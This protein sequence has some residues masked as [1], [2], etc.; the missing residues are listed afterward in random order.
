ME[1]RRNP[2]LYNEQVIETRPLRPLPVTPVKQKHSILSRALYPVVMV[3]AYGLMYFFNQTSPTM[4]LFPLIMLIPALV[5][6]AIEDRQNWKE[7][8]AVYQAEIVAYNSYLDELDKEFEQV[9]QSFQLWDAL[10]FPGVSEEL[11]RCKCLDSTLWCKRAECNDFMTLCLGTYSAKFPIQLDI[12]YGQ[13]A[14]H[15]D[16]ELK[17]RIQSLLDK[18][19][20][21]DNSPL[22]VNL[23]HH[24]CLGICDNSGFGVTQEYLA[25][26][27][28]SAIYSYGYDEV[29]IMVIAKKDSEISL[30]EGK[31]QWTRW[32]PHCWDEDKK[33]RFFAS[34]DSEKS[35]LLAY[36]SNICQ[37]RVS[38]EKKNLPYY[39][40]LVEDVEFF[41]KNEIRKFFT[42][43]KNNVG[44]GLIF[45]SDSKGLPS[46]S[47][48]VLTIDKT[49]ST[50]TNASMFGL[51]EIPISPRKIEIY[52]V[53]ELS[54]FLSSIQLTDD[55]HTNELP[56]LTTLYD[57]HGEKNLSSNRLALN[58]AKNYCY[59][60]G[61]HAV[62]G[63]RTP[64]E[65]MDLDMSDEHDGAHML[66]AGTTGSGK[67]E[68]LQTF[69]LALA[70]RY[71]PDEV[72]FVFID[73]KEGGMSESFRDLPHNAG[74]LTNIDDEIDYFAGRA[75]TMLNN[76]RKRRAKLLEPFG[77]KINKYHEAYHESDSDLVPLPHL[78]IVIDEFA[79]VISQC[80][81]F[82][83]MIISLSRVGRSL[84][85]HLVLATQSP[86]QSVDSQIWSNSNC[87]IC[88]KV[89]NEDESNAVLKVKDAAYIQTRGRAYSLT[90]G[91]AGL[92]A[93]QTAW[94]GAP[95]SA[96][97][98]AT[99]IEV[100]K[101]VNERM[102]LSKE[103]DSTY[104][105]STQLT[106][107]CDTC[108]AVK[109][110]TGVHEPHNVLTET[111]PS[112]LKL[113][114]DSSNN[115][116]PAHTPCAYIGIGDFI[117][118][119]RQEPVSVAFGN[120]NNH[121]LIAGT[122]NS[123]RSNV[124]GQLVSQL[125]TN[126]D[127][128]DI[129]FY[130]IQYGSKSLQT[131]KTSP[132]VSEYITNLVSDISEAEEKIGRT[133]AFA[134]DVIKY[135]QSENLPENQPK[136]VIVVD[137]WNQLIATFENYPEELLSTMSLNPAQYG[138]HF[139][140]IS[141]TEL[142]GYRL[143][144]YFDTKVFMK[145]DK[146]I[147]SVEDFSF[148]GLILPKQGRALYFDTVL[149][150]AVEIQTFDEVQ[151][152][153]NYV[154]HSSEN[155]HLLH[156]PTFEMVFAQRGTWARK[157]FQETNGRSILL[158]M[159]KKTLQ[160][161]ELSFDYHGVAVSYVD[162]LPKDAFIRYIMNSFSQ[163]HVV[164]ME[165]ESRRHNFDGEMITSDDPDF[166]AD[167]AN[168]LQSNSIVIMD[169]PGIAGNDCSD[170]SNLKMYPWQETL[171]DKMAAG[172]IM[173]MWIEHV[174]RARNNSF[175]SDAISS[176]QKRVAMGGR[177]DRHPF[178]G[179]RLDSTNVYLDSADAFV[180][181]EGGD[182]MVIRT[183]IEG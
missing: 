109:S 17:S 148:E 104:T 75:I 54:R 24:P 34:T 145:Y 179:D 142:I 143:S 167:W 15:R 132:I 66:V 183:M 48:S 93:F 80:S 121:I 153:T 182:C 98:M 61:I 10:N 172:Q 41:E 120:G 36:L 169:Y 86:S 129:Q 126:C 4:L 79:E 6:P 77:Q 74:A 46:Q 30:A 151:K 84:G 107:V 28:L 56:T 106:Q 141:N 150:Q 177:G 47:E 13:M 112:E 122:P 101:G 31:Y 49:D 83:E 11:E 144:P 164:L 95:T 45:I 81:D 73:F 154:D 138:I 88:L 43:S 160:W 72:S 33:V 175:F 85:I 124:V 91:K 37:S 55:N 59:T 136:L 170:Y 2:R 102:V 50:F 53:E 90:G 103:A 52:D 134:R 180:S 70:L 97:F 76:E 162:L 25:G 21:I 168:N 181:L 78:F 147:M 71:S 67:S 111:L 19:D 133:L 127:A 62:I 92:I 69:V 130:I 40:V 119:H 7:A 116:M 118:E 65:V 8:L 176:Y 123:G 22:L 38:N 63:M 35:T 163:Y 9:K 32:L 44:V 155:Q 1:F 39:L 5:V 156:I 105:A 18:Y 60:D 173:I 157:L 42:Q 131:F 57:L 12:D 158:G 174:S 99:K 149:P 68:F 159:S 115:R 178:F 140:L 87:K 166:L 110:R 23:L 113:R 96:K 29:K 137:G 135:R 16:D 89:L 20:V 82:K 108:K 139:V 14:L 94:S 51:S 3:A 161:V 125:E 100:I 58:W 26:I 27:L 117:N 64:T 146:S 171:R 128:S 152:S 165:E 114:L